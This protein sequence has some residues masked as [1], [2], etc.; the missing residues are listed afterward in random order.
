MTRRTT[1]DTGAQICLDPEA[2]SE[3]R[4][5]GLAALLLPDRRE[6]GADRDGVTDAARDRALVRV[7]AVHALHHGQVHAVVHGEQVADVDPLEHQDAALHL[8]LSFGIGPET[9]A[10]GGDT[11]RFQ[12]APERA[13]QST[14]RRGHEVVKGG[15]VGRAGIRGHAV[16]L[17]HLAVDAERDA[18]RLRRQPRPAQRALLPLDAHLGPVDDFTHAVA[19]FPRYH[20]RLTVLPR[21]QPT[22]SPGS[23]SP[24]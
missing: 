3:F 22:A 20:F 11:A 14:G 23:R 17:G 18:V 1:G 12:R 5:A 19:P 16:V 4:A 21:P 10:S 2:L 6:L 24:D 8:D 9:T 7:E 13:G 15:G